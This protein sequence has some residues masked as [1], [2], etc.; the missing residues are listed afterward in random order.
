MRHKYIGFAYISPWLIGFFGLTLFPFFASL[1]YSFTD[2][3]MIDAARFI[4]LD[5]YE[6]LFTDDNKFVQ[7]LKVTWTY[8][9][10]SVPLKMILA[11]M[12]AMLLNVKMRGIYFYRTVYYLPSIFG[13]SV[14]VAVLWK[15]LFMRNGLVNEALAKLS[16][17]PVDWLGSPH[18]ALYTIGLLPVWEFGSAMVLFL[19][20]LKNIPK[21]LYES[22]KVD[23]ASKAKSFFYVTLPF[24]T[25][26]I[27]FNLIMSIINSFQQFTPALVIT[28]GGPLQSTYLYGLMLYDNA[29]QFFKMGYASA[30]SWVLFIMITALAFAI[31]RSSRYWVHYEDGGR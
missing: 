8:V 11:L 28:N 9:L 14:A 20:A 27:L 7:S 30:Q 19:A 17:G 15:F 22:A 26:I 29:F 25:P 18:L 5:N 24:L 1:Y 21:D 16:I 3:S 12:I 6:K 23:G 2:Y 31:F 10:F 13:G 4:G